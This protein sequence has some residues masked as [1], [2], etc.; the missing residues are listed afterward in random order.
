MP[1]EY[2]KNAKFDERGDIYACGIMLYEVCTRKR[3]LAEKQGA[4]A[5]EYIIE[6]RFPVPDLA[7]YS[8]DEK[9]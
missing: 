8:I 4:D 2:I 5:L 3:W 7:L 9:V 6:S 1:P